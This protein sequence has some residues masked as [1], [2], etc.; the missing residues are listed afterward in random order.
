MAYDRRQE[1]L[2]MDRAQQGL[3]RS[4]AGELRE[5]SELS[6]ES[7]AGLTV[8]CNGCG[9]ESSRHLITCTNCGVPVGYR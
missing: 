5:T 4:I 6:R 9:R 8:T 2:E 7:T 3:P 1:R